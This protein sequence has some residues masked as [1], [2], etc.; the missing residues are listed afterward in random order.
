MGGPTS[1]PLLMATFVSALD[2]FSVAPM[3]VAIARDL[4]VSLASATAAASVYFLCYGLSQLAWGASSDRFGRVRTM[5]SPWCWDQLQVLPRLPRTL[6]LLTIA[7]AFAGVGFAPATPGSLVYI[8]DS[9][10]VRERHGPLNLLVAANALGTASA[11]VGGGLAAAFLSWRL[12]FAIP[13][14]LAVWLAIA[15]GNLPE[16]PRQGLRKGPL[17][18]I[19]TVLRRPWALL[20]M[21]LGFGEGAVVLG[22]LTFL[23]AALETS[24]VGAALAGAVVAVF[25]VS[26]L[27]ASRAS[28]RAARRWRMST[29]MGLGAAGYAISFYMISFAHPVL[30]VLASALVLG[31]SWALMPTG[32]ILGDRCGAGRACLGGVALLD[33]PVCR[34]RRGCGR[35]RALGRRTPLQHPL[36]WHRP[37]RNGPHRYGVS[38]RRG[39]AGD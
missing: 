25:G 17:R 9:L 29:V 20:V 10:P 5:R 33:V 19:G 21:T 26:V 24:G 12:A 30:G 6:L 11:I 16:P 37:V 14:V 2:R 35:G 32:P 18:Q 28:A 22:M 34:Q 31:G 39:Y 8:G 38:G 36:P 23:A 3:L 4:H 13:A 1:R 27:G 7:R 15:F